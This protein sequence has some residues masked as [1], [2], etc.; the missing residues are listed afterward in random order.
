[1][2]FDLPL[3]ARAPEAA[4]NNL[5][6]ATMVAGMETIKNLP[7][8]FTVMLYGYGS[9]ENDWDSVRVVTPK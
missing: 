9:S 1:M 8:S 3:R 2:T 5:T 7:R 6:Q 4:A